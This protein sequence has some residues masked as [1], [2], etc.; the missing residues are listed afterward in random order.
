MGHFTMIQMLLD[1][2]TTLEA[3]EKEQIDFFCHY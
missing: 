3:K 1:I 2:P